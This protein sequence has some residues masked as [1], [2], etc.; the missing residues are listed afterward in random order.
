VDAEESATSKQRE[1]VVD[2]LDEDGVVLG[3][4]QDVPREG[5]YRCVW[6]GTERSLVPGDW[7]PG[8]DGHTSVWVHHSQR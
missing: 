1:N 2:T 7:A 3:P 6:C 8:C 4:G 5:T